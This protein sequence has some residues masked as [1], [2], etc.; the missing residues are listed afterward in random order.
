MRGA[1]RVFEGALARHIT[2]AHCLE[3]R[4]N[5][6]RPE[7]LRFEHGTADPPVILGKREYWKRDS[8]ADH[9]ENKWHRRA[10]CS[11]WASVEELEPPLGAH[12]GTPRLGYLHHGIY[13]GSGYI[14][15]Y[16]GYVRGLFRRPV[17]EVELARFRDGRSLWLATNSKSPFD[18][19]EVVQRARSRIGESRYRLL[20]N[21]CEHFCE[22]C[23]NGKPRSYQVE[24]LVAWARRTVA[25]PVKVVVH[26]LSRMSRNGT[27]RVPGSLSA[28]G[29]CGTSAVEPD[30]IHLNHFGHNAKR[31]R[32]Q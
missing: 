1:S 21:N 9:R 20:T 32:M 7:M 31:E 19:S 3:A 8:K 23:L 16:A 10:L 11:N 15:H 6:W 27:G 18:R 14:V 30:S 2:A 17:E 22:W 13:V 29:A 4:V 5:E 28:T 12:L 24:T 25:A 26:L